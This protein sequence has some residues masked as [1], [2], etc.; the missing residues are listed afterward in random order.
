MVEYLLENGADVNRGLKSS[1]LHYA[2]C[3][4]HPSIAK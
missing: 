3:F 1:T 2:A 4:C